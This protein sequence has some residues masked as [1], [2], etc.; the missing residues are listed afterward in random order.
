MKLN[1]KEI[2]QISNKVQDI[3]SRLSIKLKINYLI[4]QHQ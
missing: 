3:L 2:Y 4:D 1:F